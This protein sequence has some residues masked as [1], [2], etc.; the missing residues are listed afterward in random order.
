MTLRDKTFDTR[1]EPWTEEDSERFDE[2][3]LAD[4]EREQHRQRFLLVCAGHV[5]GLLIEGQV[6]SGTHC[7]GPCKR[8]FRPKGVKGRLAGHV[9][10]YARGMCCKCAK[11]A[12][13]VRVRGRTHCE[14]CGQPFRAKGTG[15]REGFVVLHSRG[16]CSTCASRVRSR[17]LV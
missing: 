14:G 12:E 7:A 9:T 1:I 3:I 16:R 8:P 5:K 6:S 15:R 11:D 13:R 2:M 10:R 17:E 4:R